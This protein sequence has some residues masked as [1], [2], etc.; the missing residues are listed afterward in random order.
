MSS[1]SDYFQTEILQLRVSKREIYGI[2]VK[3]FHCIREIHL[4]KF[5]MEDTEKAVFNE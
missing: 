1:E 2:I 5:L 3:I 4:P